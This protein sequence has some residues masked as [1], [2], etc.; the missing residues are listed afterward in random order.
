M[1]PL[2][3][4]PLPRIFKGLDTDNARAF[5]MVFGPALLVQWFLPWA[6]GQLMSWTSFPGFSLLSTTLWSL[7]A[8]I[9]LTVLAFVP[10]NGLKNS[11]IF[12][13]SAGA[14]IVGLIW[15][16]AASAG[17][18]FGAPFFF[19]SLFGILGLTAIV[20]GL[21]L[22][23]RNGFKAV[24]QNLLWGGLVAI[25]FGLLIPMGGPM[26]L[27]AIFK[28][29]GVEMI[30]IVARIFAMLLSLGFIFLLVLLVMNI[31]LKGEEAD[32]DQVERT[33]LVLF[34]YPFAALFL[35]GFFSFFGFFGVALHYIII[36]GSFLFLSVFGVV[37][38]LEHTGRG[39]GI[40]SL[41]NGD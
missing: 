3:A 19:F 29:L 20:S 7:I 22:W 14:G 40:A 2:P 21:F 26:P 36:Y 39:Q 24:Y 32:R 38:L 18:M 11:H 23:S 27:I 10:I 8:G 16:S 9:G 35:F 34:F 33:G 13:A 5:C 30:H 1:I 41:I 4:L 17:G 12:A 25:A 6:G 28:V 15:T 31:L 37:N